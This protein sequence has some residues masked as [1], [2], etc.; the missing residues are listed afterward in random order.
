MCETNSVDDIRDAIRSLA[1]DDQARLMVEVGP[2]LFCAVMQNP[3]IMQQMFSR[4]E[5]LMSDPKVQ[6]AMRPMMERMFGS[7]MG[8]DR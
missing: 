3:E 8:R 4:C 2:G 5:E 7:M 1:S 6:K